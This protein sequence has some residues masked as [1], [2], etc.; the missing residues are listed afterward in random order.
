M[1]VLRSQ[2]GLSLVSQLAPIKLPVMSVP[3]FIAA[4]IIYCNHNCQVRIGYI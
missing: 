2:H 4:V 1:S 3:N